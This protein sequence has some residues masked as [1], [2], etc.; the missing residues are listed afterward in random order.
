MSPECAR[1]YYY[2]FSS[3]VY[4][5][6]VLAWEM[7]SLQTPFANYDSTRHFENVVGKGKRPPR[8]KNMPLYPLL[9][10]AWAENPATRPPFHEIC[11]VVQEEI[12]ERIQGASI[13]SID[14]RT[15][16]LTE[17]SVASMIDE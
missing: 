7:L 15:M 14:D 17:R 9:S 11:P 13:L 1:C 10:K 4:S 2:G 8:I 5:F 3:D 16:F 6:A 12:K